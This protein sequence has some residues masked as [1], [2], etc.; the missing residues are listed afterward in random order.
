MNAK[1]PVWCW[2]GSGIYY[3][4]GIEKICQN[5]SKNQI[6]NTER[7]N[8]CQPDNLHQQCYELHLH[9]HY[10]PTTNWHGYSTEQLCDPVETA[11]TGRMHE[12]TK[13][14]ECEKL[15]CHRSREEL[16]SLALKMGSGLR[17]YQSM[18]CLTLQ[19]LTRNQFGIFSLFHHFCWLWKI[20]THPEE[21]KVSIGI[22]SYTATPRLAS[23]SP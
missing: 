23:F 12:L 1:C 18:G 15:W 20:L 22:C 6:T 8:C 11:S 2:T 10:Q 16:S 9:L 3:K 5:E 19:Q 14:F 7:P 4:T 21:I 13:T 17:M